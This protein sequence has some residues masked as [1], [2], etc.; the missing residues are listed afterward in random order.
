VAE[1]FDCLHTVFFDRASLRRALS[2]AGLRVVE[3]TM[4]PYDPGRSQAA[5]GLAALALRGI[6]AVSPI[7]GGRFRMLMVAEAATGP[8]DAVDRPGG[9][10]NTAGRS[11]IER[12]VHEL[13]A[14][15]CCLRSACR[16]SDG[17][18]VCL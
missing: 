14:G 9:I 13:N 17:P 15:A 6:E 2:A 16:V 18:K 10:L 4:L 7:A 11:I 8:P 3:T 12:N 1:I 5:R